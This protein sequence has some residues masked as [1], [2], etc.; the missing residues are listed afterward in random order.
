MVRMSAVG[1]P[2]STRRRRVEGGTVASAPLRE[3]GR[4]SAG[5]GVQER[6]GGVVGWVK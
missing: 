1:G 3:G 6:K 4:G 5:S 2:G